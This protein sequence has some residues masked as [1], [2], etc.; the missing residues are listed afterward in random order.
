MV[1]QLALLGA[2]HAPGRQPP[3]E[4]EFDRLH[5]LARNIY[6]LRRRREAIFGKALF[7]DPAWDLLLDLYIAR[8]EARP[9]CVSS[10]C[11]AAAAP[12][13]TALRWIRQLEN[14][15]L[16]RRDLDPKDNRRSYLRLSR[17]GLTRMEDLLADTLRLLSPEP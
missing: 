3:S 16:V 17:D 8:R 1:T 13:T 2:S 5:A 11:I 15:G 9:I 4:P 14:D 7:A 12:V 10:A 6:R